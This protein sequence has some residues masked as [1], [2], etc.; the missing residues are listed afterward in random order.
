MVC[1]RGDITGHLMFKRK[2]RYFVMFSFRAMKFMFSQ[3]K[4][5]LGVFDA[6]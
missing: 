1:E 3:N 6:I 5:M 2:T 4:A